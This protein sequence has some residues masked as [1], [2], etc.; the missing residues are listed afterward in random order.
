MLR[1]PPLDSRQ[2]ATRVAAQAAAKQLLPR[3]A[4][5]AQAPRGVAVLRP[6]YRLGAYTDEQALRAQRRKARE[7]PCGGSARS[8]ELCRA[9]ALSDCNAPGS[10]AGAARAPGLNAREVPARPCTPG[11]SASHSAS[12]SL[13]G[14]SNLPFGAGSGAA[15]L[16][17]GRRE[18]AAPSSGMRRTGSGACKECRPVPRGRA[19]LLPP[20]LLS[21]RPL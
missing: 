6:S 11:T 16:C 4:P 7:L 21:R 8:A 15:I 10:T 2:V 20:G 12:R 9:A 19:P 1:A 17:L 14:P 5:A 3:L 13:L 18:R